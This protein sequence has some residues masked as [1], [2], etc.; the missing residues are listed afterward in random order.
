MRKAAY[1]TI[2][3]SVAIVWNNKAEVENRHPAHVHAQKDRNHRTPMT[4]S[5]VVQDPAHAPG[6]RLARWTLVSFIATFVVA[7]VVVYLMMARLVPDVF[8]QWGDTHVHHLS[9]GIF[10]LAV[11]AGYSL[12]ARPQGWRLKAVA[13]A[14]G[15]ALALTFDEFGMW[16]NLGGSYWQK[17]SIVAVLAVGGLL[18]MLSF[19]PRL[20]RLR[21]RQWAVAGLVLVGVIG[22]SLAAARAFREDT[23][24]IGEL[25]HHVERTGP[26]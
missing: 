11:I 25:L 5:S 4:P 15:V 6:H 7:R 2:R 23:V 12:M 8:L 9:Y 19:Y 1:L 13:T 22:T 21:V 24:Q 26:L 3:P 20:R 10:L 14:Y 18:A 16:I 17:A